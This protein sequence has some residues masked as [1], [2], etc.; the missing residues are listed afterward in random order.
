MRDGILIYFAAAYGNIKMLKLLKKY[1]AEFSINEYESLRI[2]A[3]NEH[4]DCVKFLLNEFPN[5]DLEQFK[6]YVCYKTCVSLS[7]L[8]YG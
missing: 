3:Q 6:N 8:I 2:S 4:L 7:R 5:I 1:G